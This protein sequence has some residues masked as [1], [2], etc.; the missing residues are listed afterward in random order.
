M[1]IYAIADMHSR[2]DREKKAI[3]LASSSD[4]ALICGDIT[5]FGPAEHA[6]DFLSRMPVKTLAIPGNCDPLDVLQAI[7]ASGAINLHA[8]AHKFNGCDFY[9]FGGAMP[10]MIKTIFEIPE[11][12]I[13]EELSRIAVER[14]ILVT[15]APP[16]GHLD[17]TFHGFD[18]GSESILRIIEEKKPV[19]NVFGHVH[20]AVG[21]EELEQTTLI[22]CSAGYKGYGCYIDV[23]TKINREEIKVEFL[24]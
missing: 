20:E 8:K 4:L 16:K 1:R 22:N 24:Q 3:D 12:K 18:I 5:H 14:G 21:K 10:G 7:E 11:E 17:H 9:G 13:Y 2:E 19:I 6:R 15:H 23:E